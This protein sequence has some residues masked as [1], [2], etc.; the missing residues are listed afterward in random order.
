MM[1]LRN[2]NCAIWKILGMKKFLVKEQ[3]K[4]GKMEGKVEW[5]KELLALPQPM[6]CATLAFATPTGKGEKR[7]VWLF[8][9][10]RGWI[11]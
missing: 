1:K 10:F 2:K 8:F 11:E 4:E 3:E 7:C 9:F 5:I 6:R